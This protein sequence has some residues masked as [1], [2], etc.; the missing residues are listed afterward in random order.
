MIYILCKTCLMSF[1]K[2]KSQICLESPEHKT[3]VSVRA[4]AMRYR[5]K[6]LSFSLGL[7]MTTMDRTFPA[8]PTTSSTG[9]HTCSKQTTQ[10]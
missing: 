3:K 4:R 8:V 7:L 2:T 9:A 1:S 10:Q 5:E 6:R